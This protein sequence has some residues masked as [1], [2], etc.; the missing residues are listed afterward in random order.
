MSRWEFFS[1]DADIGIR[2]I[3]ETP[4]H[5]FEM[6][7][8]ALTAVVVDPEKIA[9]Q[10][11]VAIELEEMDLDFLFFEWINHLINEMNTQKMLFRSFDVT[12]CDQKLIA[13]AS[14]DELKNIW[15][16]LSVKIKSATFTELK[17]THHNGKWT[18]QCIVNI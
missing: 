1:H 18:A 8:K 4:A 16:D 9:S 12:I 7:A 3:G 6:A 13:T 5:A 11:T 10:K 2:G 14:G 17:V 15:A